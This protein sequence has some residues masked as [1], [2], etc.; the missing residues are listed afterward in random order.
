MNIKQIAKECDITQDV[1]SDKYVD[2][3]YSTYPEIPLGD[4]EPVGIT[5]LS[6]SGYMEAEFI[7]TVGSG[8]DLFTKPPSLIAKEDECERL[9]KLLAEAANTIA[10]NVGECKQLR[11]L[12]E[13]ADCYLNGQSPT[14]TDKYLKVLST[15]PPSLDEYRNQVID[16]C[17][18][19]AE[20]EGSLN[21]IIDSIRKLKKEV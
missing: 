20:N 12:L 4:S 18:K 16:E 21:V 9:Q 2:D 3:M 13:D 15:P 8:V 11:D 7:R 5:Y 6:S 17:A 14:W 19:V 1:K 10:N